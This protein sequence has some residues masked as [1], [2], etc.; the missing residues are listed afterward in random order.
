MSTGLQ[1]YFF[2]LNNKLITTPS[3]SFLHPF[4]SMSLNAFCKIPEEYA[5]ATGDA[6]VPPPSSHKS[7]SSDS[8]DDDESPQKEKPFKSMTQ[9]RKLP[10][11]KKFHKTY[12]TQ[13]Q[14]KLLSE[15]KTP[16]DEDDQSITDL[17]P[18]KT[19]V[20][21]TTTTTYNTRRTDRTDAL[22]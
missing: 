9:Q 11:K 21:L 18:Q 10:A 7:D 2:K 20:G 6:S 22:G 19:P 15:G 13:G 8:T 5:Q 3:F 16:G 14:E 1:P 12:M 17:T 4:A